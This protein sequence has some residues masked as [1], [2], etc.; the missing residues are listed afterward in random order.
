MTMPGKTL[1]S[2]RAKGMPSWPPYVASYIAKLGD[3]TEEEEVMVADMP[4]AVAWYADRVS[5]WLPSTRDQFD[6]LSRYGA[7]RSTP[8]AGI[9]FSPLTTNQ[10][11]STGVTGGEYEEWA[12]MILYGKMQKLKVP[13]S[14]ADFPF[15]VGIPLPIEGQ[16]YL[17]T[18]SP[19][20]I[21]FD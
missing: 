8:F 2:L 14:T 20:R 3:W 12:D 1:F 17:F 16:T 9:Y 19:G 4:W 10:P 11:L 5:V 18:D 6:E 15:P 21:K 13:M 7:R